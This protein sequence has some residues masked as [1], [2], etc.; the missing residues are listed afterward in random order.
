MYATCLEVDSSSRSSTG[1]PAADS[2]LQYPASFGSYCTLDAPHTQE[3]TNQRTSFTPSITDVSTHPDLQWML[4]ST[5]VGSPGAHSRPSPYTTKGPNPVHSPQGIVKMAASKSHSTTRRGKVEQLSS[6]EEEKRRIR[7]ERNK[8]A[9]AKCRNRR[10]ELTETLQAETDT[11]EDEKSALQTEIAN[12]LKEK[13]K[14]EFILLAHKPICK[15]TKEMDTDCSEAIAEHHSTP[16]VV[17]SL[18]EPATIYTKQQTAASSHSLGNDNTSTAL[19]SELD[20]SLEQSLDLL[21]SLRDTAVETSQAVPDM[22]LSSSFY[23]QDWEP[24]YMSAMGDFEPLCTPVVTCT[25]T[26]TSYTS[27]FTFTYPEVQPVAICRGN[28]QKESSNTSSNS[29]QNSES[30]SSPTLVS[31]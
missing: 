4:Q 26:C 14:L 28:R 12:L 15:V 31:L 3:F 17:S 1:S 18:E 24:I 27:T 6:E 21:E 22:D 5:S 13:E 29:N 30:C 7:R 16:S 19:Q 25:P 23:A 9:A 10:R 8:M 2:F 11:L 20:A